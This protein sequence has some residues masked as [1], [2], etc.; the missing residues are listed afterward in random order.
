LMKT[1]ENF[2]DRVMTNTVQVK[3]WGEMSR[4]NL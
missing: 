3:T 2:L 4:G 1:S